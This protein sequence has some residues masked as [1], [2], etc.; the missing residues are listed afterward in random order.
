VAIASGLEPRNEL[1]TSICR[2]I[3]HFQRNASSGQCHAR[4]IVR[5]SLFLRRII[6]FCDKNTGQWDLVSLLYFSGRP[7]LPDAEKRIDNSLRPGGYII[8]EGPEANPKGVTEGLEVG[9]AR[10]FTVLRLEYRADRA[11]LREA[12]LPLEQIFKAATI[13]NA[14]DFR[15]DSQVGSIEPGKIANLVLL[16]T[17]PL[18]SV[19][20]ENAIR[21]AFGRGRARIANPSEPRSSLPGR[22]VQSQT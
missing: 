21:L 16:R 2:K 15:L 8:A 20:L 4:A 11:E 9:E 10:G 13:N 14:R 5:F 3:S 18:E 17:S 19:K 12:G 22:E 1:A 6:S 7:F